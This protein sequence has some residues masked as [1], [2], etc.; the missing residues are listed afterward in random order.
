MYGEATESG[1]STGI[2]YGAPIPT[3]WVEHKTGRG[4]TQ[5]GT[6]VQPKIGARRKNPNLTD[7]LDTAANY[8]ARRIMLSGERPEPAP[9][10]RHWL[11]VQT[12]GWKPIGHR[13]GVPIVGRFEHQVTGQKV[14]VHTVAA[15]FP[16][17][18]DPESESNDTPLPLKPAQAREAWMLTEAVIQK[19]APKQFLLLSPSRTGMSLFWQKL[20]R[21]QKTKELILPPQVDRDIAGDLHRTSGQHHI[22]HKVAGEYASDHPDVVALIDPAKRPKIDT[23]SYVDGRFMY[24]ALGRELGTGPGVRLNRA[25]AFELMET[26]AYARAWY[27]VKFTVPQGWRHVGIFGV[28]HDN[29][30]MGWYYPNRPGATGVTWADAS[31]VA[32]AI[33]QGWL[34]EPLQAIRWQKGGR[35]VDNFMKAMDNARHAVEINQEHPPMLRRAVVAALRQIT[36]QTVGAFASRGGSKTIV[37][38]NPLDIPADA[39]NRTDRGKVHT[40]EVPGDR[41][42][43]Q[44][45]H[46]E[47]AIQIWG[48]GRA[49]LL[50]A[51]TAT[52][53]DGGVLQ[54]PG[55]SI[56]G[57]NGDAVYSTT[58]P[59]W[60][61]LAERGGGDDGKTGRLRIKGVLRGSFA[62][63]DT[64]VARDLLRDKAEQAGPRSAYDEE[65]AS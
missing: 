50:S 65:G 3:I 51:P 60:S 52:G 55:E 20:P 35:P 19:I 44:N 21:D 4:V 22:E 42:E 63:P 32:V 33:A 45:Y 15:W 17:V 25:A 13:L 34:V 16:R 23:F 43:Q 61:L 26:D 59:R 62:T 5:D 12:P 31:E 38:E 56:I 6:T 18:T 48:R 11:L 46:P 41:W 1:R 24:A 40:Y 14:E 58:V 39:R 29:P 57:L 10:V 47:L 28:Q 27:E 9:G 36:I 30:A 53:A 64:R 49:R 54:L 7:L 8:G 37:V 2:M